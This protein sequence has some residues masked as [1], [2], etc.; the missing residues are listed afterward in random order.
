[1]NPYYLINDKTDLLGSYELPELQIYPIILRYLLRMGKKEGVTPAE[2]WKKVKDLMSLVNNHISFHARGVNP[3]EITVEFYSPEV[4]RLF[5]TVYG[6]GNATW[7]K[8]WLDT[9]ESVKDEID[10]QVEN[11]RPMCQY[12]AARGKRC[13]KCQCPDPIDDG[14]LWDKAR[15]RMDKEAAKIKAEVAAKI[16]QYRNHGD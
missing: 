14:Q 15:E 12:G 3:S 8:E 13:D 10:R 5:H 2:D 16:T 1:M 6:D 11:E 4:K 9:F 7:T